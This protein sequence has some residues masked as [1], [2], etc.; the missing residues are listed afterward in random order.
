VEIRALER[1]LEAAQA[2]A[3]QAQAT[4]DLITGSRT[5]RYTERLRD[6]YH[7]TRGRLRR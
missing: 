1:E 6:A 4:A 3:A 5:W 7:S 2:R